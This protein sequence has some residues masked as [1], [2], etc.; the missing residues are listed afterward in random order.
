MIGRVIQRACY[1]RF[2]AREI[3]D[4]SIQERV[5]LFEEQSAAEQSNQ[6]FRAVAKK[7]LA[8]LKQTPTTEGSDKLV[9][10]LQEAGFLQSVSPLEIAARKLDF[11][12]R[13]TS[14]LKAPI[15][16]LKSRLIET[17]EE[18]VHTE[19]I[20]PFFPF[21]FQYR[22]ALAF[23]DR[24]LF[25]SL[26]ETHPLF[27]QKKETLLFTGCSNL[28]PMIEG[29]AAGFPTVGFDVSNNQMTMGYATSLALEIPSSRLSLFQANALHSE[30]KIRK[31][32]KLR[33]KKM[34]V[35]SLLPPV[36]SAGQLISHIKIV[37]KELKVGDGLVLFSLTLSP[38]NP[39]M[40]ETSKQ[41]LFDE[42]EGLYRITA[43][44]TGK[45]MIPNHGFYSQKFFAEAAI[46]TEMR[47]DELKANET[48]TAFFFEPLS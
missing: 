36:F 38:T 42:K 7:L 3:S 28:G 14:A 37:R 10:Q 45:G 19:Q 15:K 34:I 43:H 31:D 20:Y 29:I 35:I 12:L 1:H 4:S 39:Y 8:P 48:H 13:A 5:R 22:K 40:E 26:L 17:I 46:E 2:L 33:G 11:T 23:Q 18:E 41:P 6:I 25:R 16:Q 32:F 30:L 24:P 44:N 21:H 27:S 47:V 9:E